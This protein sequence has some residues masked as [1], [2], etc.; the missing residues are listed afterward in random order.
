MQETPFISFIIPTYNAEKHLEKCLQSI[1]TQDYPNEKYEVLVVD[2]GSTDKTVDIV[3]KFGLK[4][5][6]NSK[7]DA[8]TAK[9]I[10]VKAAQ[11]EIIALLDADNE[12]AS[13]DWLT[14][15]IQPLV[16]NPELFGVESN[17]LIKKDDPLVNQYCMALHIADPFAR[18]LAPKLKG[19]KKENYI[20][21]EIDP[22]FPYPLGAN[23]FLWRRTII[24]KVGKVNDKFEES[25]FSA[26]ALRQG[27]VKFARV[28]GV[29]IYHYHV[30]TIIDFLKKRRKIGNKFLNRRQ[31]GKKTWITAD[32]QRKV[33]FGVFY[34]G[35][36]IGPIVEAIREYRRTKLSAWLLHP[37]MCFLTMAVYGY[38]FLRRKANELFVSYLSFLGRDAGEQLKL[39]ILSALPQKQGA[40]LL[41]CG[42]DDGS[43]TLKIAE[44][45]GTNEIFGVEINPER[46]RLAEERGLKKVL[47]VD[48]N[49]ELVIKNNSFDIV[50]AI[51]TIEHLTNLDQFLT[52]VKRVLKPE[53]YFIVSTENL[54]SWHNVLALILGNQ[55]YT[56]PYLSRRFP[57]GHHPLNLYQKEKFRQKMPPHT[58]VMTTKA[59]KKLLQGYGFEIDELHGVGFYPLFG[60]LARFFAKL[61]KNHTAYIVVRARKV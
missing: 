48:L 12:I 21:Y 29:G 61:D 19:I 18:F 32:H 30:R 51:E 47:F 4:L 37:L 16:K 10:G 45:I 33:F 40:I 35:T 52:E 42:C 36:L 17:Y 44:E 27:F 49:K 22:N 15:M 38:V 55:P 9:A 41:D 53:G 54:A 2:G 11:G 58:N 5:F 57:A 50:T 25:D 14:K 1:V 8:E 39:I 23:G 7:K 34:C 13:P 31:E 56:G 28:P 59:L 20:E 3:R 26:R 60:I 46:A 43:F 24:E 6:K